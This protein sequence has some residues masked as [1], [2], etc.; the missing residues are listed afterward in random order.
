MGLSRRFDI[1][2]EGLTRVPPGSGGSKDERRRGAPTAVAAVCS[3]FSNYSSASH[4]CQ[5]VYTSPLGTAPANI[6]RS[7]R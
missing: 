1:V 3:R 6:S 7:T 4:V 2:I 5:L